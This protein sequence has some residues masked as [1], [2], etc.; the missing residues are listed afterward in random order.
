[1]SALFKYYFSNESPFSEK[2]G[3]LIRWRH[4][5]NTSRQK[6]RGGRGCSNSREALYRVNKVFPVG[7]ASW[8]LDLCEARLITPFPWKER[9]EETIFLL[10]IEIPRINWHGTTWTTLLDND[11]D[12]LLPYLINGIRLDFDLDNSCWIRKIPKFCCKQHFYLVFH[13]TNMVWPR[14]I[15]FANFDCITNYLTD[16]SSKLSYFSNSISAWLH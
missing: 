7:S 1:M 14:E 10:F 8:T 16:N 5:L 3:A 13:A 6:G 4:L 15:E 9:R 11:L 2:A 12:L